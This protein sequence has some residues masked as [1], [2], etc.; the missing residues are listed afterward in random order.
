MNAG[1]KWGLTFQTKFWGLK[2]KNCDRCLQFGADNFATEANFCTRKMAVEPDENG[3][4]DVRLT[5][6]S[7]L[8]M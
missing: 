5:L 1:P 8:W 3:H 6:T 4:E 2:L 7:D